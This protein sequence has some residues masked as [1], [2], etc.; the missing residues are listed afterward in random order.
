MP[1][2]RTLLALVIV[3]PALGALVPTVPAAEVTETGV[4][5][6]IP[7]R[8]LV[9]GLDV[10]VGC[11]VSASHG[12][13]AVRDGGTAE[14]FLAMAPGPCAITVYL[15]GAPIA[16]PILNSTPI[17]RSSYMIPGVGGLTF[18]LADVSV[19]LVLRIGARL[20]GEVEGLVVA[21]AEASWT[22]WGATALAVASTMGRTGSTVREELPFNVTMNLSVGVGVHALGIRVL[23]RELAS[24]G[25]VTGTPSVNVPVHIDLKPSA[26][27][28]TAWGRAHT[29]I[30]VNWTPTADDDIA[31][32]RIVATSEYG[33]ATVFLVD[34][35]SALSTEIPAL[36]AVDYRIDVSV[37]DR[38]GQVS[39]V[40]SVTVRTPAEPVGGPAPPQV[41]P[42]LGIVV[43]SGVL[44]FVLGL[45]VRRRSPNGRA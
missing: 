19:D 26:V 8:E 42:L 41:E 13:L 12:T 31:S 11:D 23:S 32:Y 5:F 16:L 28:A 24:L 30:R 3:L 33:P 25:E 21:P 39:E 20:T 38:G 9:T 15:F 14:T 29:T 40:S 45:F 34:D 35:P 44:G 17:G 18:G 7:R 37:V 22:R 2:I 4:S 6:G 27:Q 1:G 36:P 10:A 43:L